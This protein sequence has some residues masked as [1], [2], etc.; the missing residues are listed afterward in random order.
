MYNGKIV[1]L[2][3]PTLKRYDLLMDLFNQVH[4]NST[5]KPDM[6]FVID[7]GVDSFGGITEEDLNYYRKLSDNFIYYK[8]AFNIGCAASWNTFLSLLGDY[9]IISNDDVLPHTDSI[10]NFIKAS[11]E[12]PEDIL[13]VS[14]DEGNAWSFFLQKKI[15]IYKIGFY[16]ENISPNYAYYEDNDYHRRMKLA[17]FDYHTVEN[18]G[19]DH[20]EGGSSTLKSFGKELK[21]VHSR[22]FNIATENYKKKWGGLPGKEVYTE[23]H[24]ISGGETNEN[25]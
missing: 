15:S 18:A 24:D 4:F 10:E 9:I 12:N 5:V 17:G 19:F 23:P 20:Q 21:V 11:E 14:K 22:K 2:C 3:V 8:P 16:D 6:F 13:F 25:D 1:S 7:N